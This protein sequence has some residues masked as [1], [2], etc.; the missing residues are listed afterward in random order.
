MEKGGALPSRIPVRSNKKLVRNDNTE[1]QL[2]LFDYVPEEQLNDL[3]KAVALYLDNQEKLLWWFRNMS[4][5][6]YSIQGW[7]KNRIYPDFI[8]AKVKEDKKNAYG[9]VHVIET[10]GLHLQ[11]EDTE[12][13]KNVFN[14][15]NELVSLK[16]WIEL[17]E[18]F[19][20]SDF[21]FHVIS[22][23]EWKSRING[24]MNE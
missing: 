19:A 18:D 10:K 2:S 13:K 11:N 23:A 3:E 24:I 12:Y 8:A 21:R 22:E 5:V 17:F 6:D 4:R 9:S 20:D 16:P 15:C 1:V 7:R 14:L